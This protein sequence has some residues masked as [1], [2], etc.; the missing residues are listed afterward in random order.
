VC[1][2]V[3]KKK[4]RKPGEG[5]GDLNLGALNPFSMWNRQRLPSSSKAGINQKMW[6]CGKRKI[7]SEERRLK[8]TSYSP[9]NGRGERQF[10]RE[11]EEGAS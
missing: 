6:E 11:V 3:G 10:T 2:K 7:T 9:V 5:G 4:E 8:L 1:R